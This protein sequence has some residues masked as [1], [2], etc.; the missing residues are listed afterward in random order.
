MP[1]SKIQKT[2]KR[3]IR[4]IYDCLSLTLQ[5]LGY[6]QQ[7]QKILNKSAYQTISV[8][9]Q[10][11]QLRLQI[12]NHKKNSWNFALITKPQNALAPLSPVY[13]KN[14]SGNVTG[15]VRDFDFNN[16]FTCNRTKCRHV[17]SYPVTE[18]VEFGYS[19]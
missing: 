11:R 5:T 14:L 12:H 2:V 13:G 15:A 3:F 18:W 1:R 17:I 4:Q 6:E 10:D 19:P 8:E 7:S 16:I 9:Y